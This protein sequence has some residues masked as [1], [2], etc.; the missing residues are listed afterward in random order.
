MTVSGKLTQMVEAADHLQSG[1]AL[2]LSV[3]AT[4]AGAIARAPGAVAAGDADA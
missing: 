4:M 3:A 2:A 1:A